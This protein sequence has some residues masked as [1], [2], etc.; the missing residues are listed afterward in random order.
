M[1]KKLIAAKN[2]LELFR[3]DE[4]DNE[5]IIQPQCLKSD[6]VKINEMCFFKINRLTFD[7]EYPHREA[8]ENVLQALDNDAFNFVYIL[9][10]DKNGIELYIGVVKNQK[11]NKPV[12][13]KLMNAANYGRNLVGSFE[14][15]FGGSL[16]EKLTGK[17]L[18][19]IVFDSAEKFK[20]AGVILGI[21]SVNKKDNDSK[22][23]FQGIDRL[24]NSMLGL[25]WRLVVVCEP[26]SKSEIVSLRN[27][28]Y[29]IYNS[30]SPYAH[31]SFQH[32]ESN[33]INFSQSTNKSTAKG[34]SHSENKSHSET[35]GKQSER[36]NSSHSD[37]T[38]NSFGE[39]TTENSGSSQ[40]YGGNAGQSAS[41]TTEIV[42]K[43]AK[44][45]IDYID[46]E[47]LERVK[48]GF[49]KGL[50]KTSIY[51]MGEKPTDAERLKVG[52]M[53]LFQGNNS[54]YS[55]LR[56]L[57]L[58]VER[59]S[60]ILTAYQSFYV[61][62]NNLPTEKLTLL[63]R[64]NFN[65]RIEL[66]TYLTTGEIS[67]IAGL[68]QKEIPGLKVKE[69]VDFGLN[70]NRG[71][72]E[73]LLGNL[74]Q[75]GRELATVPVKISDAVL[76]KHTF[77]AGV[78][79]SGKTTT[80]HKILKET[81]LNFLVIEP[82]TTE[83]RNFINSPHFKNVIV[84]TVGDETTAPFR[85]NPFELVRGESVSSHADMLKATF[86]SAFPMEASMPQILEEAIYKIYEDKGWDI[87]SGRNYL[88]ERRADYKIG[89]EFRAEND[90]FP[91]LADF[92]NA[93]EKI[94][95]TKGFSDRLR[96]DYRGSLV[97]RFSNL[98]KGSKGA[99]FNCRQSTNFEKLL[100][101]NV[102]IEMENLKS[103]ED[104]ALL[105]GFLLTR[106]TAVIKMRHRLNK[107]FRHITLIEEAH[108]LLS[109][110]EF[111]DNGSKRTAVETFTDLLAEVR[112]YG[113]SLIV[114]DQ[115]PN[116]LAPEVLK[117]TNTKIIHRLF[118]RDDK[119][120]VGDTMLMD[121]KQKAFLSALETGQ[122]IVFS[123]GME[124]P[125]HVKIQPVTDT[126]ASVASNEIVKE[127]F[128]KFFGE[129]HR[130]AELVQ[131]FYSP[132]RELIKKLATEKS[133]TA[134]IS[135]LITDF[136]VKA[137]R[138]FG[139]LDSDVEESANF[140]TENLAAEFTKRG[141]R[142]KLF[143]ERLEKFLRLLL[144]EENIATEKI[145]GNRETFRLLDD[146][147]SYF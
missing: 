70:F 73:I 142:D 39:S 61:N 44:E 47:L 103:A 127:R 91:T 41:L 19:D 32:S 2:F 29:E 9:N 106:L 1:E 130:L 117:N 115:I 126:G 18:T 54:S 45:I 83:Y 102:V 24:I 133:L 7:E 65:G 53:S 99:L 40:T 147:K 90:A 92:L 84:F 31:R 146:F 57:P 140:F 93:L 33:G 104:K 71:D 8:F 68:P 98:T 22:Y 136:K 23:G 15:N 36:T 129:S 76:N 135:E 89:D 26:V 141:R 12:L 94:V 100:D 118:A 63:S 114:V 72:G 116:K 67:L 38:G 37:Q 3:N 20:N 48:I 124:R 113:E 66:T 56:S 110:V 131:K 11:E 119:E 121:D 49:G 5:K 120:V 52:I 81:A 85:L 96:D 101:M 79:G 105:M 60:K 43:C 86:T 132:A 21:P 75:H 77:I 82:S 145:F 87:D 137:A 107:N 55:L 58:D 139:T 51:Y 17:N 143:E 16:L 34:T 42:N 27:D 46:K 64:P 78:T 109:R 138:Y 13:G 128:I 4:E 80:C 35:S 134:G 62:E 112:K 97:S 144:V 25:N 111:G 50:F 10:G 14:G 28:I 122:A 6:D 30:V 108:R 74:M 125:V 123:E 59:D 69:S 95:D 88:V